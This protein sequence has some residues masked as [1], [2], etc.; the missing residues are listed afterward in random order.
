MDLDYEP[1][2]TTDVNHIL[3]LKSRGESIV[4]FP[5]KSRGLEVISKRK[6][7]PGVYLA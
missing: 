2:E 7:V 6:I 1:D 5:T 4:R 3:S